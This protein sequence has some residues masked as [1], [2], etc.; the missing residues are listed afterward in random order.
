M[1]LK[2]KQHAGETVFVSLG[3]A[4]LIGAKGICQNLIDAGYDVTR[5]EGNALPA[6]Q[7]K[8]PSFAVHP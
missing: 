5:I 1:L 7:D 4:H 8:E 6:T 3:V 2:A